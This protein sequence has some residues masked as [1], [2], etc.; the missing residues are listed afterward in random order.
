MP[1][2][3]LTGCAYTQSASTT[4][5][6]R[7]MVK[8][9]F[10][11]MWSAEMASS[12]NLQRLRLL[13]LR[14]GCIDPTP[15]F[16]ALHPCTILGHPYQLHQDEDLARLQFSS[17]WLQFLGFPRQSRVCAIGPISLCLRHGGSSPCAC[18]YLLKELNYAMKLPV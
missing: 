3:M 4:A 13:N 7:K 8:G 15:R 17:A 9:M 2:R 6:S 11:K 14:N 5:G 10:L 18:I 12:A 16:H 1:W